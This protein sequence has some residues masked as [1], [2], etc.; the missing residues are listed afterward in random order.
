MLRCLR[1]ILRELGTRQGRTFDDIEA[2]RAWLAAQV[3]CTG[4][5]AV[6]GF[7]MGGGNALALAPD[8]G[9]SA[10]SSN[11]GGCPKDAE[12]LLA[13]ACPIVASYGGKDRSPMG[14]R[15]AGR[16]G[17][18]L[19]ANGVDHDIKVYSEASH[20]FLNDHPPEDM[21][22]LTVLLSKLSGTRYHEPSAQDAR[23]RI[24]AFFDTHLKS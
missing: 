13:G 23:R 16:L 19:S 14:Y 6:I 22:L 18:A 24:V 9:F 21:T 8:R 17:R 12:R 1:T 10:S 3:Q 20:G 15:A 11:Y 2:A 5:I 7:C 4:R